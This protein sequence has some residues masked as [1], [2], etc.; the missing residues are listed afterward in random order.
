MLPLVLLLALSLPQT[1]VDAF[2]RRVAQAL[3]QSQAPG[4]HSR[5]LLQVEDAG[6]VGAAGQLGSALQEALLL[7]GFELMAAGK[8]SHQ[9]FAYLSL[10]RG[11]PLATVRILR[12]GK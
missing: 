9:V 12:K 2:A 6:G 1:E 3:A 4:P 8:F 5:V 11:R 10:R 7:E